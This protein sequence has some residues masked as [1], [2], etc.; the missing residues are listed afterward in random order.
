MLHLQKKHYH[1]G[2]WVP[3]QVDEVIL[4]IVSSFDEVLIKP[5]YGHSWSNVGETPFISFDNWHVGHL[6]TDYEA[7]E[8]LHGMAYFLLDEDGKIRT[9]PNSNY[10]DLPQPVWLTPQQYRQQITHSG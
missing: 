4:V 5:E 6:P 7:I 10:V 8:K 2:A 3:K 1:N 9:V